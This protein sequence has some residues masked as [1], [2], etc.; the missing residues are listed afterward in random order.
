[1]EGLNCYGPMCFVSMSSSD[2]KFFGFAEFL[3]GLALMVL[4][5]TIADVRYR[6]RL[7]TAPIPLQGITF[8]GMTALGLLTLATDFWR[9][10]E[11][12]VPVGPLSPAIWQ[13]F[14]GLLFLLTFLLWAW[15]AFIR[16]P[17]YGRMNSMRFTRVLYRTIL[18]GSQEEL[19][20]VADELLR[21]VKNIIHYGRQK[22]DQFPGRPP[23][24]K[25]KKIEE[26]ANAILLLISDPRF[27]RA[28]VSSAPA[29][30]L[31]VFQDIAETGKFK[32]PVET[33]AKNI[34]LEAVNYR[35]S[36]LYHE[37]DGYH[38]GLL[39]YHKPL[40]TVMFGNF[41]MVESIRTLLDPDGV[42]MMGW[43][44]QQWE[45]YSRVALLALKD[46]ASKGGF[47]HTFIL[48]R[49]KGHL[50]SAVRDLYH[51]DGV[52][53]IGWGSEPW[54]KLRVV[55]KFIKDAIELL[56]QYPTPD[57]LKLRNHDRD[58]NFESV[59]DQLAELIFEVVFAASTVTSPRGTCWSIQHNSVWTDLFWSERSDGHAGKV[60]R[61]KFRRLMYNEISRMNDFV[62]F[63]GARILG[64]C[65]NVMG[66]EVR[67]ENLH[68]NIALQRAV[69]SWT[70]KNFAWVHGQ[71]PEVANACLVEGFTF[72]DKNSQIVRTYPAEG[73]RRKPVEYNFPV[74]R[75]LPQDSK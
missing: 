23:P 4:A 28:I 64:Y 35:D 19:A 14:L 70:K 8:F 1:L 36:F 74:D 21:S 68:S 29:T 18:N 50:G 27:C 5:W 55:V 53:S 37:S 11:W 26:N 49:A 38:T 69:L 10:Q 73:L 12:L 65:L 9:A 22:S 71:N 47:F 67:D 31:A 59:Y 66:L 15:F 54:S 43:D 34:M 46:C 7:R 62:N 42:K 30:A 17:I 61:F 45:A 51:L 75:A 63:K 3:S 44:S 2:P 20:V 52:E 16:P 24:P 32:L 40:T 60:I 58:R 41:E 33:F 56:D 6:F 13:A 48:F 25:M 72:D 57:G 39:G